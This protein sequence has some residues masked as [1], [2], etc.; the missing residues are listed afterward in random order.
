MSDILKIYDVLGILTLSCILSFFPLLEIKHIN[1]YWRDMA[2]QTDTAIL[3]VCVSVFLTLC[4][5]ISERWDN[6]MQLFQQNIYRWSY[7]EANSDIFHKV[8]AVI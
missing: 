1:L 2:Y 8:P 4:L 5:S 6:Y 7:E 3:Q